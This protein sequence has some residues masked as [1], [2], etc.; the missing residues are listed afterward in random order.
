MRS[1][2]RR[3][4]I[5]ST[6]SITLDDEHVRVEVSDT[7]PGFD[8]D[9]LPR[10]GE[11]KREGGWGWSSSSLA[12]RW[13]VDSDGTGTMVWFEMDG[14]ASNASRLVDR[15]DVGAE[16]RGRVGDR[17]LDR[18]RAVHARQREHAPAP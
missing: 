3:R 5:R 17:R 15:G 6:W 8:P 1:D 9:E 18:E 7:G 10:P 16:P 13:G 12:S 4:P 14:T 11:S 2:T